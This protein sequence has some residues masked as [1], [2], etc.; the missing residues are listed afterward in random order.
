MPASYR[1]TDLALPYLLDTDDVSL[2]AKGLYQLVSVIIGPTPLLSLRLHRVS[3]ERPSG[4]NA[5]S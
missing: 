1:L 4:A 5:W 2:S 3:V